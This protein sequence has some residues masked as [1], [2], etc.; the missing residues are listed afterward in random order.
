MTAIKIV[1]SFYRGQP[2]Y[3]HNNLQTMPSL[4][5]QNIT[6]LTLPNTV[7]NLHSLFGPRTWKPDT[8]DNGGNCIAIQKMARKGKL[9]ILELLEMSPWGIS[10]AIKAMSSS[11]LSS[12]ANQSTNVLVK[13][14]VSQE[15]RGFLG[16][17]QRMKDKLAALGNHSMPENSA[18]RLKGM[19][20]II[21]NLK[22]MVFA[23]NLSDSDRLTLGRA[24]FGGSRLELREHK[25]AT[26]EY[27]YELVV[28]I[29]VDASPF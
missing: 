10:M 11:D 19:K 21:P 13:V 18:P 22:S 20:L 1:A 29:P 14:K 23:G 3:Y 7:Y 16:D 26:A 15:Q 4:F 5:H 28:G 9:Q 8:P 6:K 27:L 2:G 17:D 25:E 12:F 24:D